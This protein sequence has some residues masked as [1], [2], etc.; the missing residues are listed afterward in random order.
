MS[1]EIGHRKV[2]LAV[3]KKVDLVWFY[4]QQIPWCPCPAVRIGPLQE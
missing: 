3:G 2:L 4:D 1:M